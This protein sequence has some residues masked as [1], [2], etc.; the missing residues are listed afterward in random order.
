MATRREFLTQA[1]IS[2][3]A[4]IAGT[5]SSVA[6]PT[7]APAPREFSMATCKVPQTDIVV[8]RIAYGCADLSTWDSVPLSNAS[9]DDAEKIVHAAYENGITLFDHGDVYTF[10]KSEEAFGRV[11]KRSPGLRQK[12]VLQSKTG[13]VFPIPFN[14][15]QYQFDCS[16]AHIIES[17]NGSLRRFGT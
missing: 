2:G 4:F 15:E 16:Y 5:E 9:V 6:R 12:L 14:A 10:G 17:A 7:N 11:L 3:A 8:S 13:W 1:S